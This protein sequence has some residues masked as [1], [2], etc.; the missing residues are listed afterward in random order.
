MP[1]I[2]SYWLGKKKG[3][4]AYVVPMMGSGR[5]EFGVGTDLSR[6]PTKEEDGTVTRSGAVCLAC[7]ASA[8]L[9]YIRSEGAHG[10]MGTQ[11]M[12]V[13]AEGDRRRIYLPPNPRHEAAAE[14]DAPVDSP[15]TELS[16]HPQYMGTPRYGLTRH[17]DLFTARQ[18]TLLGTLSDLV[19]ECREL[20]LAHSRLA[21]L[22]DEAGLQSGGLGALAYAESVATYLALAVSRVSSTNSTLCRWRP[23]AGKESVNDTFSRQALSMTWDF[24]E[25]CPFTLPVECGLGRARARSTHTGQVGDGYAGRRRVS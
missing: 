21:G 13:V 9:K 12:T 16:T 5:M 24:A 15:D 25:G 14:V 1:L 7:G 11:L 22:G 20:V 17:E 8:D 3:K 6:A 4:E 18:L 19:Q 23:D 2:R 10:R